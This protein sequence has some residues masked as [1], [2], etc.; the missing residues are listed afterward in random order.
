MPAPIADSPAWRASDDNKIPESH[1]IVHHDNV[2]HDVVPSADGLAEAL[3]TDKLDPWSKPLLQLYVYAMIAFLCSTMNGYDGSI[4]GSLPA[5]DGF[6]ERFQV[7]KTGSK[8]GYI[9]AM[10]TVGTIASLPVTGPACDFRGRRMGIFIGSVIV[11]ASTILSGL[12]KNTPQFVAGR[13]FLGFGVSITRAASSIWIAEISP[14]NYRGVLTAFYNC[15]YAVGALM[16]AGVTRGSVQYGGDAAWQIPVWCQMICPAIV[17]FSVLSFPESP[18]WMFANHR[19][20][21]AL[22]FLTKYHGAG[23]P[24][25]PLVRLQM[26]EYRQVITLNGSDKHW[27][28]YSDLYKTRSARWRMFNALIPSVWGQCSGNAVVSYYLPAM[29]ATAGLTKSDQV[30]NINLGYTAISAVAAYV[31]ASLIEKMGR[32]PTCIWTSVACAICFAGITGGAGA[33]ASTKSSTAASAGIAFI[34]IFGWCYN[35]GMTPL[36]AL[37][38]VECLSYEQ[39]GK[40]I[41]FVF[42]FVHALAFINQFCFP[43]ALQK[44]GWYTYIIF[45]G[46]DFM[47]AT[48]SYFF[49]VETRRRSLEEMSE[50]FEADDPVKASLR[51]HVAHVHNDVEV[52]EEK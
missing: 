18:R 43:I 44:I 4:F 21:Q 24:D 11:I 10:Y 52:R 12:A 16:A 30:L 28:D 26:D 25:H 5:M 49:S 13:F 29:L 22:A 37:Y 36:Q 2:H 42:A 14:P 34:F 35:F 38:P 23:R 39:R 50:I 47:Q 17:C 51:K 32:R 6:R 1:E 7:E 45:I 15:T 40:G 3:A 20:E 41:A 31:G 19:E 8:L 33:Y 48:V 27:W 46:W 9:S